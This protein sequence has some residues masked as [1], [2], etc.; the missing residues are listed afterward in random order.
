MTCP[1]HEQG[2]LP[3]SQIVPETLQGAVAALHFVDRHYRRSGTFEGLGG[4]YTASLAVRV[5]G[6]IERLRLGKIAL[7]VPSG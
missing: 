5:A 2:R 3:P 6:E 7:G 4:P 1:D